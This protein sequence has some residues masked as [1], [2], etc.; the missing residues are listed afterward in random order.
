MVHHFRPQIIAGQPFVKIAVAPGVTPMF[1]N[2][3]VCTYKENQTRKTQAF[4]K[5]FEKVVVY[6]VF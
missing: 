5:Q 1:S 2:A 4:Q 6:F 3:W